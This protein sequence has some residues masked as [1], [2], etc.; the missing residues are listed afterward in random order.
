MWW[1]LSG[2]AP[3]NSSGSLIRTV[4]DSF[5]TCGGL[6]QALNVLDYPCSKYANLRRGMPGL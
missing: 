4:V 1:E 3:Y 5:Q 2:D 6:E